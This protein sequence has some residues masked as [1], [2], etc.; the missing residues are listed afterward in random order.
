MPSS[1]ITTTQ[2]S[3]SQNLNIPSQS[4]S[5]ATYQSYQ[6]TQTVTLPNSQQQSSNIQNTQTNQASSVQSID[7][8]LVQLQPVKSVTSLSA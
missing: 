8:N 4:V 6:Q 1:T 2:S 3:N 7:P 5:S